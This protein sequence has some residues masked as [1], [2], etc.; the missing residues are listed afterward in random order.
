M[1]LKDLDIK[2]SLK[3]LEEKWNQ[4]VQIAEKKLVDLDELRLEW[5]DKE[6]MLVNVES[7][8][9]QAEEQLESEKGLP[10]REENSL[11]VAL[12]YYE[13]SLK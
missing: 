6:E 9:Y 11:K 2:G 3:Q 12:S 1:R 7:L 13:V 8:L 5:A 4:A 10:S